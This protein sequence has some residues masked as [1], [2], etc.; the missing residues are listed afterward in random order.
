MKINVFAVAA[1]LSLVTAMARAESEGNGDPFA[2][3][4][5]GVTTISPR[6]YVD[7]GSAA[8][9]DL[10]GRLSGIMV[11]AGPGTAPMTGSEAVVQTAA[12]L[13]R[14]ALSGTVA[15]AQA[16]SV[17]RFFAGQERRARFAP[18]RP[19]ETPRG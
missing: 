9:P 10:A 15:D 14:G 19:D 4:A 17:A 18:S 8:F 3:Q 7:T 12:S 11:A 6:I 1:A 2:F 13:P 16:R 5:P